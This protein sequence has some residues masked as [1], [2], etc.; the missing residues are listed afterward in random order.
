M[1]IAETEFPHI[2]RNVLIDYGSAESIVLCPSEE[3][4]FRIIRSSSENFRPAHVR[5]PTGRKVYKRRNF[6]VRSLFLSMNGDLF[7]RRRFMMDVNCS[8]VW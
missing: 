4:A 3:E 8:H 6:E 2:I 1:T 5:L 7:L